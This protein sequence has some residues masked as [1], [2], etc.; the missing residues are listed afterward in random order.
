MSIYLELAGEGAEI[1]WLKDWSIRESADGSWHF[2]G[3]SLETSNGR[4]ST[5]I[6]HLDRATR[7]AQTLN[8]QIY[9]LVG[10]SGHNLDAEFVFNSFAKG[11]GNGKPWRNVSAELI[12]DCYERK[13]VTA[14]CQEVTLEA[15]ARLLLLS[16]SYVRSLISDDKLPGR[17]AEDGVQ[18]IPIDA[19]TEYRARMRASLQEALLAL[20]ETSQRM[21]LYDPEAE[22]LQ[23]HQKLDVNNK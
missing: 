14:N 22:E 11:L 16:R 21:G 5:K 13:H 19:L 20:M 8:G 10:A 3:Y 9:Q 1:V 4:L 6:V 18:W 2:V 17:V 15:A 7:T 12:P 23:E